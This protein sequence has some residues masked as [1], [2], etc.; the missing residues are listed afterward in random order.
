MKEII[1]KRLEALHPHSLIRDIHIEDMGDDTLRVNYL[2][3]KKDDTSMRCT[4][5]IVV[6]KGA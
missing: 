1:T 3:V 2:K 5:T 4:L 6:D